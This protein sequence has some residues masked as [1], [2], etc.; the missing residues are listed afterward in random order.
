MLA[1]GAAFSGA[2]MEKHYAIKIEYKANPGKWFSL[3][4]FSCMRKSYAMGA[5]AM[6]KAAYDHQGEAML[7]CGQDVV[8]TCGKQT[9]KVN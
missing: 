2:K 7:V 8:D 3:P 9:V 5:W 4:S 1:S 6:Y